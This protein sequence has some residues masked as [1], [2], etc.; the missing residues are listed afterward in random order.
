[1]TPLF[2]IMSNGIFKSPMHRVVTNSEKDRISLVM[3]YALEPEKE[4]EP[5]EKLVDEMRPR[6]Y[7]KVKVKDYL[8]LFFQEF[9]QGKRAIDWAKL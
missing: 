9:Q 3:F 5:A 2:Q 6:S 7:R 8:K 1:M 4:L